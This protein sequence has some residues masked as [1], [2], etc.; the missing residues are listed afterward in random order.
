M[1]NGREE[2][3]YGAT[4]AKGGKREKTGKTLARSQFNGASG[5]ASEALI[6][7]MGMSDV[8]GSFPSFSEPGMALMGG[9]ERR[10]KRKEE[11]EGVEEVF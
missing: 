10:R 2:F 4:K 8:D 9:Q 1:A 5:R 6:S 11:V 3:L 7:F